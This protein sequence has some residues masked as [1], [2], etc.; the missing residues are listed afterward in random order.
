MFI[1]LI[2]TSISDAKID[3]KTAAGIWSFDEDKGDTAKDY[4]GEGNHGN[5]TGA[6]WV[7]GKF[8]SALECDGSSIYVDIGDAPALAPTTDE[9]S[10]ISWVF[11]KGTGKVSIV[12][13]NAKNWG[14][15]FASVPQLNGYIAVGGGHQHV[16]AENTPSDEWV[17]VAFVWDGKSAKKGMLYQNGEKVGEAAMSGPMNQ[18]IGEG[19]AIG[20]RGAATASQYFP[21]LIDEVAI[22]NVAL[23]E[24]DIKD[25]MKT[26]FKAILAVSPAGKLARIWGD[27]KT[28]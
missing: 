2:F 8:G 4:S 10:V 9:F 11:V 15:R 12:E 6:K 13:N 14:F 18:P 22:F 19:F 27:I 28:Q 23:S 3:P 21:G 5:I 24:D 16:Y 1:S 17:H 26:G 7:K 20:R 25:I